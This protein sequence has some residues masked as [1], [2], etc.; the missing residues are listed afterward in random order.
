MEPASAHSNLSGHKHA[1]KPIDQSYR[2]VVRAV[3]WAIIGAV[4]MGFA[5]WWVS[6]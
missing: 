5:V 6:T 1:W 3:L 2:I 4:F